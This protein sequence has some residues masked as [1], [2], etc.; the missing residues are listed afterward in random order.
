MSAMVWKHCGVGKIST[1]YVVGHGS[2]L[3][4]PL[5]L[6]KVSWIQEISLVYTCP[7]FATQPPIAFVTMG[8]IKLV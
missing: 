2:V 3:C 1:H 6:F 5:F 8:A 4:R 7:L